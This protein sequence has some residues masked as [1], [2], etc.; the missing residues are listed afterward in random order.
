MMKPLLPAICFA[1]AAFGLPFA[2]SA[3]AQ[4]GI[5][6]KTFNNVKAGKLLVDPNRPRLYA[7]LPQDNSLAVIDTDTN[8]VLTTFFIGSNPVG[9]SISLDGTRLYVANEG[10]TSAAIGV[11]DLTS[12]TPLASLPAPF[13][14]AAVAAG[15]DNRLYVLTSGYGFDG[16]GIA[17]ID[18]TTGASQTTFG[19]SVVYEGG[20]LQIS[21]DRKTL[22][23]GDSGI[24]P[25]TLASFDVS[26]ATPGAANKPAFDSTGSNGEGL[27]ISHNGQFLVFPNG[28]GNGVGGSYTTSLIPTNNL[29]GV[30]GTFNN[31][32]Y[33][34]V[35]TFSADD[36]LLYQNQSGEE[37][38]QIF[39]TQTFTQLDSFRSPSFT[40]G[41]YPTVT[42]LAVTSPNGYLYIAAVGDNG[43]ASGTAGSL[44][45]VSTQRAPFFG[46]SVALSDGFYYL[47][48]SDGV[49]FGYYNF[50]FSP[51]LFH[52]DLGFEYPFDA[53]DGSAGVYLYDFTAQTFFYTSRSLF[54][55]LY[56]FTLN[57]F[58][59]YF[60][61]PTRPDHYNTDGTRY[62]YNFA[63]GTIITR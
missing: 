43:N 36:S 1:L 58:L 18:A 34:G 38:I 27:T 31:G 63:T 61:D 45:L 2:T 60:P 53:A 44:E 29:S 50:N 51:Y 6:L 9:M 20:F 35:A 23:F 17:Q 59:Y 16:G 24:S 15:L 14:P 55:Y 54:P 49:P 62:F 42:D 30:L 33:P 56:D 10:S 57:T 47:K 40:D 28:A 11:V 41:Y 5:L 46:G 8:T 25:S 52:S 7:T 3:H 32:A 12:L 19:G 4:S 39:S 37:V 26:T 13:A 22:F 21:P 48:F